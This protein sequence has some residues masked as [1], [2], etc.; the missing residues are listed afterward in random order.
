[1]MRATVNFSEQ[2]HQALEGLAARSGKPMS[3]VLRLAISMEF[4]V[5]HERAKGNR[6]LI[7]R[8]NGQ[9]REVVAWNLVMVSVNI[10]EAE[11]EPL[12]V[13]AE[14]RGMSMT[15]ALR[16]SITVM[17]FLEDHEARGDKILVEGRD[18][19][20]QQLFLR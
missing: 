1:M 10:P 18:H 19:K 9:V 14:K 8:P 13:L 7:E 4:W 11:V 15:G 17:K 16:R 6:I 12:R 2:A 20:L 3:E 5:E